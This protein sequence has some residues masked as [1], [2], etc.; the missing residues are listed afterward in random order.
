M[1]GHLIIQIVVGIL[2]NVIPKLW[3]P[4]SV[5]LVIF[6]DLITRPLNLVTIGLVLTTDPM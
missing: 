3:Y 5:L 4:F 2:E 1:R 6:V